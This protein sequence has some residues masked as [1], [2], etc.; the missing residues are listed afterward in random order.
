LDVSRLAGFA[1]LA[2]WA[3]W[4]G[5]TL[6]LL[7]AI[8]V[9]P[10]SFF[11]VLFGDSLPMILAGEVLYGLAAGFVYTAALYYALV[12]KN[13]SVDAGGAHEGLIGLGFALGP[14]AGLTAQ[15]TQTVAGGYL[16]AM[17][18]SV[19]PLMLLC[20]VFGLRPLR[21]GR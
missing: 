2:L 20:T 5:K 14:L 9:M 4:R 3:G 15:L 1:V 7:V 13:A 18:L 16:P 12:V 6:P 21:S 10:I 8:V 11:L 17:L 19:A